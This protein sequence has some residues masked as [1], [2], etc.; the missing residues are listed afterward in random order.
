MGE[1]EKRIKEKMKKQLLSRIECLDDCF[2][3]VFEDCIKDEKEHEESEEHR[4]KRLERQK[5]R[6]KETRRKRREA[7][8]CMR[9]GKKPADNG[10]VLCQECRRSIRVY[11]THYREKHG[12]KK[13]KE[14]IS[15]G[16][17]Y[18]CGKER[19]QG[20]KVCKE[21]LEAIVRNLKNVKKSGN[22]WWKHRL[23]FG[24]GVYRE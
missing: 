11:G 15:K 17:C 9:C 8:V 2:N 3:C 5:E 10:S 14:W 24:K 19:V 7:G 13:R 21:C 12:G 4:L 22:G 16:L 1:R 20:K 18:H 23:V 6:Q